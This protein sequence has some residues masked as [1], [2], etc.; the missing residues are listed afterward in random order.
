[1]MDGM[2]DTQFEI[3]G[4]AE[5]ELEGNEHRACRL[6]LGQIDDNRHLQLDH[7]RRQ[8]QRPQGV[9]VG[10]A[11]LRA[12]PAGEGERGENQR[13]DDRSHDRD[14]TK[15]EKPGRPKERRAFRAS[16]DSGWVVSSCDRRRSQW[17][18]ER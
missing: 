15:K 5:A 1:T 14:P 13:R 4:K 17:G 16:L 12:G 7:P 11:A 3:V 2:E 6:A 18:Y 9:L 8:L 10:I